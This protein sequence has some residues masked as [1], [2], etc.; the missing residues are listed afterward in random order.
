MTKIIAAIAVLAAIGAGLW[1]FLLRD[2]G[3][4]FAEEFEPYIDATVG[5]P[6]DEHFIVERAF[7]MASENEVGGQIMPKEGVDPE[8]HLEGLQE[9]TLAW[10]CAD[11]VH[12]RAIAAGVEYRYNIL[13]LFGLHDENPLVIPSDATCE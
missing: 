2:T 4:T 5:Q 7:F 3:P 10:M 8:E 9:R 6:F 1:F 11:P 13:E 12:A